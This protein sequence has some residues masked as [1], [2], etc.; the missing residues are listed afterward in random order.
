MLFTLQ[1]N[2][3]HTSQ[4]CG[5]SFMQYW[6]AWA[7]WL[8]HVRSDRGLHNR[9]YFSRMLGAHGIFPQ[10]IGLESP[11]QLGKIE[12]MGGIWEKVAKRVFHSEKLVGDDAMR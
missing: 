2:R 4:C 1:R 7:G 12:R 10:R 5:V 9:G 3:K 11:E 6:V 8:K